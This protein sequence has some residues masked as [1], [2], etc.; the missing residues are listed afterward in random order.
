MDRTRLPDSNP[1]PGV[2]SG[3]THPA[4]DAACRNL[5]TPPGSAGQDAAPAEPARLT[6]E[7]LR[8]VLTLLRGLDERR[9]AEAQGP[10]PADDVDVGA[11]NA[12]N[13]GGSAT[14]ARALG[15]TSGHRS[16]PNQQDEEVQE[17]Q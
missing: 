1:P 16:T 7:T 12:A 4:G 10:T 9:K 14:N 15:T 6:V 11:D 8:R 2:L 13:T 3:A 17:A 5:S